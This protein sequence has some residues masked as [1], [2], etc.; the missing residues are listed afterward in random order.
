M[1]VGYPIL[2]VVYCLSSFGMNRT[3]IAINL[4]VFPIGW[5]ER[6]ASVIS[7]PVQMDV[8]Y[9][10]LKSLQVF[11]ALDFVLRIGVNLVFA[12]RLSRV[13]DLVKDPTEKVTRLYPKRHRLSVAFLVLIHRGSDRRSG[14]ERVDISASV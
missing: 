12:Y 5:F 6:N 9:K 4:E 10:A 1:A 14:G 8:I 3:K 13:A 11:T 2:M 7:D